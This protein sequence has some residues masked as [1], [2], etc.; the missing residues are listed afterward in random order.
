MRLLL[1]RTAA[2]ATAALF[3][4]GASGR[5]EDTAALYKAKC[6]ACH[7]PDGKGD[8][9]AG[10][11]LGVRDFHAPEV[12]KMSDAELFDITKKGKEKMPAYDKKLTDDQI[13]DLV[14]YIR[15]LK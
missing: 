10:K 13:K 6:A 5:A 12:A 15:G 9:A 7:G 8:T 11:K 2:I 1:L 14:K 4:A 3:L